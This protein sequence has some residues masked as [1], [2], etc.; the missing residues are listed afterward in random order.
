MKFWTTMRIA[1]WA[2]YLGLFILVI[3]YA[4]HYIDHLASTVEP[5][6]VYES[7]C[8]KDC[9]RSVGVDKLTHVTMP[10][11]VVVTACFAAFSAFYLYIRPPLKVVTQ[12][13]K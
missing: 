6:V 13:S 11:I 5:T 3:V 12:L 2:I 4:F 9:I 7:G 1:G 8:T 10:K